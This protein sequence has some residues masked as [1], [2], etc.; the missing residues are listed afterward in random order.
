MPRVDELV[1]VLSRPPADLSP[2]E[3]ILLASAALSYEA[4]RRNPFQPHRVARTRVVA[5]QYHVVM[6]LSR[7][8]DRLGRQPVPPR[9]H[10]V[11]Q[12][13][14]PA[15]RA[16]V[17]HPRAAARRGAPV[18]VR[19]ADE[20]PPAQAGRAGRRS[21]TRWSSWRT[22]CP[23]P[24][25]PRRG[26]RPPQPPELRC[27][28]SGARSTSASPETTRSSATGTP[29][30]TGFT[31]SAT[32]RTSPASSG[33]WRCSPRRS[34]PRCSPARA[35]RVWTSPGRSRARGRR[36]HRCAPRS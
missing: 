16:R 34:T 36:R 30:P 10:G 15:L 14:D 21:A 23:S 3:R 8:P 27:S 33:S 1:A 18:P 4:L 13:G 26:P 20:L 28:A 31:R 25:R 7:Q 2:D 9:H 29:S 6:Q 12:R 22:S 24:A 35:R 17:Q 32:A 5:Y 11:D 19:A